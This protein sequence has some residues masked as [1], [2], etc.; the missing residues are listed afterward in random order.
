MTRLSGQHP[1]PFPVQHVATKLADAAFVVSCLNR[2]D[3]LLKAD[4]DHAHWKSKVGFGLLSSTA[5]LTLHIRERTPDAIRYE[6]LTK[7]AG[8]QGVAETILRFTAVDQMTMIVN[9][10]SHIRERTGM[11]KIVAE[12][13]ILSTAKTL[14]DETWS[15]VET[16][17][18]AER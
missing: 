9:Y 12:S 10:E 7:I 16:K 2:V 6:L 3:Q 18:R 17:L 13:I 1:L 15:N 14:I 4:V 11:L 8:G 5:D